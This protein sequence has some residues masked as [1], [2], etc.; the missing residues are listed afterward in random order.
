[1]TDQLQPVRCRAW[2]RLEIPKS[3]KA[4]ELIEALEAYDDDAEVAL[5]FWN[6]EG[7]EV[8]PVLM[9]CDNNNCPAIYADG[10]DGPRLNDKAVPPREARNNMEKTQDDQREPKVGTSAGFA[11]G[12]AVTWIS[13]WAK[14]DAQGKMIRYNGTLIDKAVDIPGW[15][16]R[17]S[18]GKKVKVR[19][20]IMR[21]ANAPHE[22][23]QREQP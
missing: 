9:V 4:K 16:V 17:R 2:F 19:T 10:W 6:G 1:M 11:I 12:D 22:L 20:A 8:A 7:S 23:P 14:R 18:D 3:M 15:V 13:Q 5:T 21:L